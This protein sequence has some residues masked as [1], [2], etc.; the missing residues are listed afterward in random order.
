MGK[1]HDRLAFRNRDSARH[2]H[3]AL[4]A[5]TRV[6]RGILLD[7]VTVVDTAIGQLTPGRTVVVADG[8]IAPAGSVTASGSAHGVDARG[9]FVVP[10]YLDMHAHPLGSP[11]EL[12]DLD[13]MLANGVTGYREMSGSAAM[14]AKRR[15]GTLTTPDQPTL[16][17]LLGEILTRANAAT[18]AAAI[19]E[20]DRQKADGADF[21]KLVDVTLT[22]F[23]AVLE[24][25]T[26][27][28]ISV[29]FGRKRTLSIYERHRAFV[30]E[31][32]TERGSSG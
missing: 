20:I 9:R 30:I 12:T 1:L 19:A 21:I 8:R 23:P 28:G 13:L 3:P 18:P 24:M 4:A 25:A 29:E 14:L 6:D 11:G 10:G 32:R 17:A 5:T 2:K 15:A 26:H 7:G 31:K 22:T 16:L 27:Q